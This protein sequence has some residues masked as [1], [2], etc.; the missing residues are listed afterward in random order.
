LLADGR[1]YLERAA[2]LGGIPG[3]PGGQ[4]VHLLGI[5]WGGKWAAALAA[6][7]PDRV[8]SLI[9]STPGLYSRRTLGLGARLAVGLC[10]AVWP[11]RPFTIPLNDPD[12]FTD[13]PHWRQFI[14]ADPLRLRQATARFMLVSHLMERRLPRWAAAIRCPTLLLL[15]DRDP[16]VDNERV[17]SLLTRRMPAGRLTVRRFMS[18]VHTLEFVSDPSEYFR[19]LMEWVDQ[20]D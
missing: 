10:A 14:D 20:H 1:T 19:T 16:I 18:A 11:R 17:V 6:E 9:L 8:A 15:A 13:V 2:Q 5:S 7:F 12:L 4:P 3:A